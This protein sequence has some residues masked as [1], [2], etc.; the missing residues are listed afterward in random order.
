MDASFVLYCIPHAGGSAT[1]Y[2]KWKRYYPPWIHIIPLELSGRGYRFSEPCYDSMSDAE[3]DLYEIVREQSRGQKFG[4]YGHSMGALLAF[5]LTKR[6][7]QD[8]NHNL[9]HVFLSACSTPHLYR[10]SQTSKMSDKEF[11]NYLSSIGGLPLA[12]AE[13]EEMRSIYLPVLRSDFRMIESCNEKMPLFPLSYPA[14]VFYGNQDTRTEPYDLKQ[15]SMYY[16]TVS[17]QEIDGGH[18]FHLSNMSQLCAH[19]CKQASLI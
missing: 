17:F 13:S 11:L 1:V 4:L 6:F 14:T 10:E 9:K 19:I 15:W 7:H 12:I 18:F 8:Q 5:K 16:N 2:E 3:N